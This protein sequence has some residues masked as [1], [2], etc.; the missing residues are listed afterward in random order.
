M[1][2]QK[3]EQSGFIIESES[4][5]RIALD[6]GSKTSPETLSG[7][8]PVDVFLVS[9]IHGDHFDPTNIKT[10][11]P[12]QVFLAEDCY[13]I[14]FYNPGII[15]RGS[16][17]NPPKIPFSAFGIIMQNGFEF[18]SP[19]FSFKAFHVDHGPNVSA[20][21][22]DNFG[23]LIEIDG[24]Q[25]YFAGDMYNPSGIDVSELSPDYA[26]LPVG[27]HYT[28]G[29]EEAF[30]FAKTFKSIGTLVPMHYEQSGFIDPIRKDEFVTLAGKYFTIETLS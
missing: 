28:F 4:G 9:H 20:P 17:T 6:I 18:N 21:L 26:L 2:I 16:M 29:P 10:L 11:L 15:P 13:R 30:E 25:I 24:K 19:D 23:F 12:K 14:L 7:I 5:F 22:Q 8:K 3:F 27:G 1:K